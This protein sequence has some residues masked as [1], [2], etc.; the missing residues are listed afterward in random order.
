MEKCVYNYIF[1]ILRNDISNFQHGFIDKRSTGSNLTE[2]YSK[3]SEYL[4]RGLQFDVIFLDLSKAFD[5]VSHKLL[6]YKL[7]C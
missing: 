4:D 7:N 5:S 1:P 2:F 3:I 6:N